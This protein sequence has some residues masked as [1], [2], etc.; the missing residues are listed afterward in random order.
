[1]ARRRKV[2]LVDKMLILLP[3]DSNKL[4]K[5]WKG[6]FEVLATVSTNDY[7][8]NMS[9]KEKTVHANLLKSYITRDTA[10]DETP[11]GNCCVPAA[12]LAVV[13]DDNEGR[14]YNDCGCEVLPKLDC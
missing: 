12:S 3:T 11:T 1:M 13:E 14:S 2:C 4:F 7:H 8:R 10:R 6:P 9:G 5:Q